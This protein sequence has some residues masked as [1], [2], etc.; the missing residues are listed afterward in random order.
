[1]PQTNQFGLSLACFF[2]SKSYMLQVF[3]QATQTYFMFFPSSRL[4]KA[5]LD[6]FANVKL[7]DL[8]IVKTLGVGGFGRVEL[9][10]LNLTEVILCMF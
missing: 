8:T 9:V 2:M 7:E 1:M 4:S 10:S 5:A 6:E 3:F